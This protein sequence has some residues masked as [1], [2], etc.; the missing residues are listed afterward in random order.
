MK[1]GVQVGQVVARGHDLQR[2]WLDQLG[3]FRACRDAGFDFVSWGHHWLIDPF[4][5]FQPI[6]V[7]ARFAA[8]AGAMDLVTGVLLT[9]LLNPVQ[10]AEDVATL[11]H[12]CAGRLI[13]GIGLGYRAEEFEAA[14]A[15][16]SERVGR[17]E[18][19]LALMKRLWAD[20]EVTH[21]GRF[22]RVTG[23]RP[24]ARPHQRP[25]P[26]IW[27]AA[28]TDPAYRR[29]GRLGH[30]FYALGTLTHDEIGRALGIW[31][32]ALQ[33]HGHPAPAEIPV[34]RE[35]YVASTREE[36]RARARPAV[37][38][39]YR[40]YAQHGLPTAAAS[41][42]AGVDGLM[43]AP[44]VIGSPDGCLA[45]LARLRELGT[46]HVALRLFWPDMTQTEA[47]AMIELTA[48]KLLPA[49]HRL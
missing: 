26:R 40:G 14:G 37:E 1:V 45:A 20:D 46:T 47:L 42:A 38:A 12:I 23:A 31:R 25:H 7:L 36:A 29:A 34:H 11:D 49:L 18:E 41:M 21:H 44:F 10:V 48:A 43:D 22:Y 2:Q 3:Q 17:F 5:H 27:V 32:E 9:P 28:M 8:E 6:P 16:M 19:S 35:F 33:T 39:K 30:P 4:Q 13:F 15:A 24:T